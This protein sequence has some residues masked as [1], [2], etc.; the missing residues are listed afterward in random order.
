MFPEPE[1]SSSNMVKKIQHV[2]L[3]LPLSK[4]LYTQLF[5]ITMLLM[6]NLVMNVDGHVQY[7]FSKLRV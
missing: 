7:L 4:G 1:M 3:D 5:K 2:F 6:G